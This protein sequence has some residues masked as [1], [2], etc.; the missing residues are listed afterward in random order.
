MESILLNGTWITG[1]VY[2]NGVQNILKN[3][4]I[5][6]LVILSGW[7]VYNRRLSNRDSGDGQT[8]LVCTRIG[9]AFEKLFG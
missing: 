1:I 9:V 6:N 8:V 7:T 4:L 5:R 3:A 2:K